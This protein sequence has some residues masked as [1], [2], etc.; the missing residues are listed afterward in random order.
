VKSECHRPAYR[1]QDGIGILEPADDR[2]IEA[3]A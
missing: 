2:R 1:S 3:R